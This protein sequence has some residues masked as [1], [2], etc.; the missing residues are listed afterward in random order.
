M[1]IPIVRALFDVAL[2]PSC[3]ACRGRTPAAGR[4]CRPCCRRLP[5]RVRRCP[6]CGREVGPHGVGRGCP[7]CVGPQ[8][9]DDA[10]RWSGRPEGAARRAIRAVVAGQAYAGSAR[11]LVLALQ[12]GRRLAAGEPL[13]DALAEALAHAGLPG[14]LL[15]PVPLSRRRRRRRGFNQSAHLARCLADRLVGLEL[16]AGALVRRRHAPPQSRLARSARR[17][18]P[19]GAFRARPKRVRGRCVLLVDDVLTTGATARAC[20]LAL[21]RAGALS[22]VAAVACRADG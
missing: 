4:L 5:Q 9:V 14:D 10:L 2:P 18:G 7:Q 22:V 3:P 13:A 6:S 19:R 21:R 20:A 16:C 11:D 8:A 15:V 12:F 1:R 17:R